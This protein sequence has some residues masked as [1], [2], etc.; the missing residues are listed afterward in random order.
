MNYHEGDQVLVNVAPF[1][2]SLRRNKDSV[3]CRVIAIHGSH[4][5]VRTE[6][7]YREVSLRI[8]PSWIERKLEP[9]GVSA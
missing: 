7:P 5:E 6:P 2:G 4:V 1:I 9:D 3:P 8:L